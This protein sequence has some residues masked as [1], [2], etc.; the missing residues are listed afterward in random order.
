MAAKIETKNA[1]I[2]EL[3]NRIEDLSQAAPKPMLIKQNE[4]LIKKNAEMKIKIRVQTVD[5]VKLKETDLKYKVLLRKFGSHEERIQTHA[6]RDEILSSLNDD[7]TNHYHHVTHQNFSEIEMLNYSTLLFLDLSGG[8]RFNLVSRF[9]KFSSHG[10]RRCLMET[11]QTQLNEGK[12]E[13]KIT[14]VTNEDLDNDGPSN[15][16]EEDDDKNG[17][18]VAAEITPTRSAT[19][20]RGIDRIENA[21]KKKRSSAPS[22]YDPSYDGFD[23]SKFQNE[24][25]EGCGFVRT[26]FV[27]YISLTKNPRRITKHKFNSRKCSLPGCEQ[28]LMNG[29]TEIAQIWICAPE[30][31]PLFGTKPW[32][33]KFHASKS[34][35]NV[36][37][38][39]LDS[40]AIQAEASTHDDNSLYNNIKKVTKELFK[41]DVD[42]N[43]RVYS[44]EVYQSDPEEIVASHNISH[45]SDEDLLNVAT[46]TIEDLVIANEHGVGS[47]EFDEN[48]NGDGK[49]DSKET[50]ANDEM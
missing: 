10:F 20:V 19:D 24:E 35:E 22:Q 25:N 18:P 30:N 41:D 39:L 15:G 43:N 47:T 21:P 26:A 4:D 14:V 8:K 49:P 27:T 11:L 1:Y 6:T 48:M 33:C 40:A 46:N 50:T 42:I 36:D 7:V 12:R 45:Q 3:Q 23:F 2:E 13:F 29:V 28:M 34:I 9:L 5:I 32:V 37:E 17:N 31:H 38:S 16:G 44:D